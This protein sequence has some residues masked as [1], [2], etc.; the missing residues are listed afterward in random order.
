[1]ADQKSTPGSHEAIVEAL[2]SGF[3]DLSPQL[4]ITARY[5]IDHPHEVGVQTMR[6]LASEADVHPNS[7][8]RLARHL[9]FEGYE[10]MRE[11]FR[12]FVRGGM[13]SSVERIRWL[14][15]MSRQGGSV[16]VIGELAASMLTNMEQM[17][18]NLD[19]KAL[20]KTV[21]LMMNADKVFVLGVG[22]AYPMAYNFWYVSR[23]ISDHFILIPRHG[24]LPMDD[25]HPINDKNLLFAMTFQPYR[26]D[27]IECLRFAKR[28]GA[29]T[30]GLSDSPTATICREADVG[31][32]S[33]THTPQFFHSNSSVT[34]LIETLCALL[35][36][37]GGADALKNIE[38]FNH[39]RWE[40][41][42]YES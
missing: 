32:S 1:M 33:P 6:A 36:T 23:M 29:V 21:T 15:F 40:S 16:R 17:Y 11:R 34:A 5:I 3:D 20:D 24:S 18:Q 25:L 4:Q 31:L 14:Q 22:A 28:Q 38:A 8:V 9:G 39:R 27:V 10:A 42:V 12:D 35:V 2:L 13:G 37:Q 30:V 19:A 7:F 26:T 41:G